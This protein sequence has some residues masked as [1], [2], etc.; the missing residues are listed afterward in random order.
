MLL[1]KEH[2]CLS[3]CSEGAQKFGPQWLFNQTQAPGKS[4][5]QTASL[6]LAL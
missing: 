1:H 5:I 6:P 3:R 2:P 4:P